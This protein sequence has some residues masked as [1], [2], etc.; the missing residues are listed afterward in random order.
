MSLILLTIVYK[1]FDYSIIIMM[2]CSPIYNTIAS[3]VYY[4]H[5]QEKLIVTPYLFF[6]LIFLAKE[7]DHYNYCAHNINFIVYCKGTVLFKC[8]HFP[9]T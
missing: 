7:F 8:V 3:R 1:S 9:D 2:W 4:I 6:F 5:V